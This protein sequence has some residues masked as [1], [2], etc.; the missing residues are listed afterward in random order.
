MQFGIRGRFSLVW[1]VTIGIS[2]F[3]SKMPSMIGSGQ[4][5]AMAGSKATL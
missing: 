5:E 1:M 4:S 3:A 2:R